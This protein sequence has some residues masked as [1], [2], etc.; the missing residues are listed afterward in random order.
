MIIKER[1]LFITHPRLLLLVRR[2]DQRAQP[3]DFD[4]LLLLLLQWADSP[5]SSLAKHGI[6]KMYRTTTT[7]LFF[8]FLFLRYIYIFV[9]S[10]PATL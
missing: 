1:C 8:F 7:S 2:P 3:V 5:S 9:F 10:F 6:K 4:T